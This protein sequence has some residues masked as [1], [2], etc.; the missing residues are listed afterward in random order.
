MQSARRVVPD[1]ELQVGDLQYVARICRLTQGLPLGI[2]L[3]AAWVEVLTVAE[4]AAE[5]D[6]SL[7]F[8]ETELRD[9]PE[10]QRSIRAIFESSWNRLETAEQQIFQQLTV[11]R[12]GFTREAAQQVAGANLRSLQHL[13]NKS[14][15]R[16]DSASGRYDIHEL[17][18]Q[19]GEARLQASAEDY[20]Q[21]R[22]RHSAYY[23]AFAA[24]KFMT[25][26]I[27]HSANREAI[28]EIDTLLIREQSAWRAGIMRSQQQESAP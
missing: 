23:A 26:F 11:F 14:L 15:L 27:L 25:T 21:T 18:R 3:A 8:L 28:L 5:I 9:V 10:R 1:F 19:Y 7:D 13:I 4:I 17:L 16:R 6:Q 12:G 2:L 20:A 22:D 24:P